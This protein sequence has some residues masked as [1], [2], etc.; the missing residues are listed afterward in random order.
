MSAD[1]TSGEGDGRTHRP[2]ALDRSTCIWLEYNSHRVAWLL[3]RTEAPFQ[4]RDIREEDGRLLHN[5]R[6]NGVVEQ[7]SGLREHSDDPHYYRPAP[8]VEAY[9]NKLLPDGPRLLP[10]GH[11]PFRNLRGREGYTCREDACDRVYE[12]ETIQEVMRSG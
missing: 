7:V 12:R 2:S 10:C 4:E 1:S 5:M 3:K 6:R 8:G 11:R 9:L